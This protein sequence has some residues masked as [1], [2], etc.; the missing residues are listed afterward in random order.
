MKNFDETLKAASD[1][2]I[3]ARGDLRIEITIEGVH[4]TEDDDR[5]L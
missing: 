1:G 5:S 4:C 3:V 2:I